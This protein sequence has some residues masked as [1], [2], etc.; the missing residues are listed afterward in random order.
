MA[1]ED[2]KLP[3]NTDDQADGDAAFLEE[4]AVVRLT[5]SL[6]TSMVHAELAIQLTEVQRARDDL[7]REQCGLP[8]GQE[9]E[10]AP[11]PLRAPSDKHFVILGIHQKAQETAAYLRMWAQEQKRQIDTTA[12]V[13]EGWLRSAAYARERKLQ[14]PPSS[15]GPHES[16]LDY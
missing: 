11:E 10:T 7:M 16:V 14:P 5:A 2:Y 1:I 4:M 12:E 3:P 8:N 15:E 13:N 6:K 9:S